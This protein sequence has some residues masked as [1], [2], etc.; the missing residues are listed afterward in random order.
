MGIKGPFGNRSVLVV[1]DL[2]TAEMIPIPD[3]S[4]KTVASAL[5]RNVFCRCCIPES[6][7]TD[8][9]CKFDNQADELG[10]DKK[11]ISALHPQANGI[12][13]RLN[14]T[15]GEVLWKTTDQ[16]GYN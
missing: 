15:I 7:L 16:C 8:R 3:K 1:V 2:L 6:I 14:Q 13:E 5:I 4:A 11:R 9:G 10:I 12:V